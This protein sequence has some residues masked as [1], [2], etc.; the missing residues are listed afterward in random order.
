MENNIVNTKL[1]K[2][3]HYLNKIGLIPEED[4]FQVSIKPKTKITRII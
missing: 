4:N 1:K 3:I 2:Y